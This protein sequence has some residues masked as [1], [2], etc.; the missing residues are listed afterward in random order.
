MYF[1]N[2]WGLLAGPVVPWDEAK[3]LLDEWRPTLP[4]HDFQP[5]WDLASQLAAETGELLFLT[6]VVPDEKIAVPKL[7]EV[8]SV[9]HELENVSIS[10]ARLDFNSQTAKGRVFLRLTNHSKRSANVRVAGSVGERAIFQESI[11]LAAEVASPLDEAD[12]YTILDGDRSIGEFAVN[13]LTLTNRRSP[14]C[15]PVAAIRQK[16]RHR[17]D[18]KL[19][20]R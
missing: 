16:R 15:V 10:A 4:K 6:D 3:P 13:F 7:M 5:T 12:V 19:I 17:V 8:A 14:A 11:A 2:P 1:A 20:N 18:F 9:G